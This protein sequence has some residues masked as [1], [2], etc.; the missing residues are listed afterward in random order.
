MHIQLGENT[1]EVRGKGLTL[2]EVAHRKLEWTWY[3]MVREVLCDASERPLHFGVSSPSL[4]MLSELGIYQ[5]G[6]AAAGR[7]LWAWASQ[8]TYG[9]SKNFLSLEFS[10]GEKSHCWWASFL[11]DCTAEGFLE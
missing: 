2:T 10:L 1:W 8:H 6:I 3:C 9:I 7:Q 4:E 5:L 11:A